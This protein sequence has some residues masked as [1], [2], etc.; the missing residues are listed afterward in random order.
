M[1]G[2]SLPGPHEP[3]PKEYDMDF[4]KQDARAAAEI[5]RPL[6]IKD[7][8]GTPYWDGEKPCLLMVRGAASR[9]V[10][11]AIR[12]ATQ[13]QM[14]AK[15]E[16]QARI[17]DDLNTE[18]VAAAARLITGFENCYRNGLPC[19]APDDVMWFLGLNFMS[20]VRD[21]DGKTIGPS[22]AQQVLEFG[23]DQQSFLASASKP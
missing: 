21:K 13:A 9:S 7:L 4:A 16:D 15:P 5:S 1:E 6:H 2:G 22:F 19:K 18:I 14:K 17:L 20:V 10:Q 11:D 12:A 8:N 23:T 3:E